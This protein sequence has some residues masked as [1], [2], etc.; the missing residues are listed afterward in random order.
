MTEDKHNGS[1][2]NRV[3]FIFHSMRNKM[4]VAKE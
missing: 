3:N 2:K 4:W 1:S